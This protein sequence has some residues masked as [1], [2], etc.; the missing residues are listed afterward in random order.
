VFVA[1]RFVAFPTKIQKLFVGGLSKGSF[2]MRR[3]SS[4]IAHT[5]QKEA[6]KEK[7]LSAKYHASTYDLETRNSKPETP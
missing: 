1:L 7:H 4:R 2:T 5:G 6:D 3:R